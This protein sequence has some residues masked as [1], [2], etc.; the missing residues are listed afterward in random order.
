MKYFVSVYTSF[1]TYRGI[2]KKNEEKK[3]GNFSSVFLQYVVQNQWNSL[4]L[5]DCYTCLPS[6]N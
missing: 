6:L 1:V 4:Y 2:V 5:N 3:A